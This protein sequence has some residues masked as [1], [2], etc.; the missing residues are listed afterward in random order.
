MKS[1]SET[2]IVKKSRLLTSYNIQNAGPFVN[3]LLVCLKA[4]QQRWISKWLLHLLW[5]QFDLV[6][7][8]CHTQQRAQ[9]ITMC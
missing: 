3:L 9:Y 2:C 1:R 7:V 5:G 4:Q 6:A 8:T